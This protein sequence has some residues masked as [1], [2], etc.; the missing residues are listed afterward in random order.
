MPTPIVNSYTKQGEREYMEDVVNTSKL[1]DGRLLLILAD[2]H[3]GKHAGIYVVKTLRRIIHNNNSISLADAVN[4]T[5]DKWDKICCK[6]M[7][8][9]MS[10]TT[11]AQRTKMFSDKKMTHKY[12]MDG[13]SSGSTLVLVRL[14]LHNK[15]GEILNLGDSRAVYKEVKKY[16]RVKGT[17]DH[18]PDEKFMGPIKGSVVMD[19]STP[20]INGNLAVGRAF[21]DNGDDLFGT[22]SRKFDITNISWST[23]LKLVMVS[24]GVTDVMLNSLI[25]GKSSSKEIVDK[26]LDL[27]TSDNVSCIYVET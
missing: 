4:K 9:K 13:Y 26:A 12:E 25:I 8:V 23:Q 22:I 14:D 15:T 24:D 1:K 19:G 17:K 3:G 27:G 2:G 5:I 6:A 21:G 20:R 11:K 16:A 18:E 7:S 10:P